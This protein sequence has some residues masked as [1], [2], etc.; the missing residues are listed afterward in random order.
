TDTRKAVK[1]RVGTGKIKLRTL[2]GKRVEFTHIY[3]PDPLNGNITVEG[4]KSINAVEQ[5]SASGTRMGEQIRGAGML[6]D[7]KT[8]EPAQRRWAEVVADYGN[9]FVR[10]DAVWRRM[11]QGQSDKQILG[12][13]KSS[14]G[15]L[16]RE[17]MGIGAVRDP[18][19]FVQEKRVL[20]EQHFPGLEIKGKLAETNITAEDVRQLIRPQD[21]RPIHGASLS[22]MTPGRNYAFEMA[23][24]A[25]RKMYELL[26]SR[27]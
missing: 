27:L 26:G 8:I 6:G 25:V 14:E 4:I 2:A 18:D 23:N 12:W 9:R 16:Y 19:A 3:G 5:Y 17:R 15:R 20:L 1:R 10:K 24:K 11:L 7:F 22:S 21:R 13:L